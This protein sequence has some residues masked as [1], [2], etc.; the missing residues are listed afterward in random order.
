MLENGQVIT[1]VL[2]TGDVKRLS[3]LRHKSG[4][5]TIWNVDANHGSSDCTIDARHD[6]NSYFPLQAIKSHLEAAL[7]RHLCSA[8]ILAIDE[9][10]KAMICFIYS[11]DGLRLR[12]QDSYFIVLELFRPQTSIAGAICLGAISCYELMLS[13]ATFFINQSVPVPSRLDSFT[14]PSWMN[15]E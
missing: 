3:H 9:P 11:V 5:K 13:P 1:N 10:Y 14:Q 6:P 15:S 2:E 4:V 8:S 7:S 12:C